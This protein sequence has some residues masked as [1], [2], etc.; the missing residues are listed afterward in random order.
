MQKNIREPS[1]AKNSLKQLQ[2]KTILLNENDRDPKNAP[3]HSKALR[4]GRGDKN[5]NNAHKI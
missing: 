3:S 2:K 5:S 1:P 4:E